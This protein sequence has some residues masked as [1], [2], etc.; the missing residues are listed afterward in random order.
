MFRRPGFQ[1]L[2][3]SPKGFFFEILEV[4]VKVIRCLLCYLFIVVEALHAMFV[5][6]NQQNIF[7]GF[8]VENSVEELSHLQIA[9][10][11]LIFCEAKSNE[12]ETPK[13]ILRWFSLC[14]SL[15]INYDKCEMYGIRLDNS[16]L[17]ALATSFGCKVG[18]FPSK[19]FVLRLYVGLPKGCLWDPIV[20]RF[21]RRLSSWKGNY[22]PL[23]GRITLIKIGS[24]QSSY[25]LPVVF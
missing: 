8:H 23:E 15:K 7:H 4:C 24:S 9:D 1:C 2:Y 22:L 18:Y 16:S 5:K 3:G 13:F 17:H 25:P 11:T 12:V 14:S 20:E 10:D 21:D 19:Y 6:A